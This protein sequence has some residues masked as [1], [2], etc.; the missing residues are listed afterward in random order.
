LTTKEY[1]FKGYIIMKSDSRVSDHFLAT[2]NNQTLLSREENHKY[3][4][5][6]VEI[7]AYPIVSEYQ[8]IVPIRVESISGN[9]KP[10]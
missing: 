6:T 4:C 2:I 10:I 3:V 9:P 5:Y 7:K 1:V 8:I